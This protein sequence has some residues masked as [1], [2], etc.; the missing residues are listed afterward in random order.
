M[1]PHHEV[2]IWRCSLI[3]L[4]FFFWSSPLAVKYFSGFYVFPSKIVIISIERKRYTY[5][6]MV[7]LLNR[8]ILNYNT[9]TTGISGVYNSI[10]LVFL[11][12]SH[13]WLL[14]KIRIW[15][16]RRDIF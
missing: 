9:S 3:D 6:S 7:S 13:V 16:D 11:L 12:L 2:S 8:Y 1:R 14:T 10:Y 5:V 4:Y 15:N